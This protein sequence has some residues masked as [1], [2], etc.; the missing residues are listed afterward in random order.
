MGANPSA[1][2]IANKLGVKLE[3][4]VAIITGA[5][6]GGIGYAVAETLALRGCRVILAGR[7][8]ELNEEAKT[9]ILK[10]VAAS[11]SSASSSSSSSSA[12]QEVK[13]AATAAATPQVDTLPLDLSS[14][15]SVRQFVSDFHLLHLPLHYLVNNAGE[16]LPCRM[17]QEGFEINMCVNYFSH[18][19]LT[20]LLLP[21][22][23]QGRKSN[24]GSKCVM[25]SALGGHWFSECAKPYNI[26][27]FFNRPDGEETGW[28]MK[29]KKTNQWSRAKLAVSIVAKEMA[30][31]IPASSGLCF[32]SVHPGGVLTRTTSRF[33]FFARKM[34]RLTPDEGAAGI[35]QCLLDPKL[36][37]ES[38]SYYRVTD[39][40]PE[41]KQNDLM[42]SQEFIDL[43]WRETEKKVQAQWPAD[44]LHD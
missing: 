11:T 29:D 44:I 12:S 8:K 43:L 22:L 5:S 9:H 14:L 36:Q 32:Y 3:G 2:A 6:F 33:N 30:K 16:T 27:K 15:S 34:F 42:R 20:L 25:V 19:L 23:W 26:E 41:D 4:K 39:R 24:G 40:V 35:V 10:T 17:T 21:D 18:F 7:N 31:R 28:M 38:G 37:N 1:L 13:T